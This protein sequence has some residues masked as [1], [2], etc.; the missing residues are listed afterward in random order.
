MKRMVMIAHCGHDLM[1]PR[2]ES[3][4]LAIKSL[5]ILAVHKVKP[6]VAL[7]GEIVAL[8]SF[9]LV[10]KHLSLGDLEWLMIPAL[11]TN[12]MTVV[13]GKL[14][15]QNGLLVPMGFALWA[16]VSVDVDNKLEAQQQANVPF[17][18]APQDWKSG[19]IP[20]LLA[21][22]APKEVAQ[23]LVKKIEDSVFKDKTYKR[24][25]FGQMGVGLQDST[26]ESEGTSRMVKVTEA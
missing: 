3:V 9:S 15:D 21:V 6:V 19:A 11:S 22:L 8:L 20:W 10:F 1:F 17:R 2:L 23:A 18:L 5:L 12:Q 7:F 25:A 26:K 24:F 13:R 4:K 16:H 14:K